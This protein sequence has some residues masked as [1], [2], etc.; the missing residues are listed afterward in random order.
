[1][2]IPST[3]GYDCNNSMQATDFFQSASVCKWFAN[4]IFS[5]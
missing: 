3:N 1:M 4:V 2:K 5:K